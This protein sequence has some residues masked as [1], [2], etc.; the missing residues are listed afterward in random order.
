MEKNDTGHSW[1]LSISCSPS[2]F[3]LHTL[4]AWD[5]WDL[6]WV[7]WFI[8]RESLVTLSPF[9]LSSVTGLV[10]ADI[11]QHLYNV[12]VHSPAPIKCFNGFPSTYIMFQST[13]PWCVFCKR[14]NLLRIP[15]FHA[16]LA[17]QP[18]A[19]RFV[20]ALQLAHKP[21]LKSWTGLTTPGLVP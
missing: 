1:R 14:P 12:S 7:Q 6:I 4:L 2:A 10:P 20:H 18:P 19:T 15:P 8:P 13:V 9:Y 21:V 5:P 11:P 16:A 17:E 3:L